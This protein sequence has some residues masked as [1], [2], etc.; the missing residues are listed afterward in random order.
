MILNNIF[1][2]VSRK[3]ENDRMNIVPIIVETL[4]KQNWYKYQ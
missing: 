2:S 1:D 4:L 3:C